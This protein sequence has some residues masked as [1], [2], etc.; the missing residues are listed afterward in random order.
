MEKSLVFLFVVYVCC[1]EYVQLAY[2][3][4]SKHELMRIA[5]DCIDQTQVDPADIHAVIENEQVP[6]TNTD[7]YKAFLACSYKKQGYLSED[8]T[9]MLYDNLFSFLELFYNAENLKYVE[10]CKS[11]RAND[12]GELCFKNLDCILTGLKQYERDNGIID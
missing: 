4:K 12:P 7:K 2:V 3:P 10:H 6:T 1:L 11:I 8:G 9:A 5:K